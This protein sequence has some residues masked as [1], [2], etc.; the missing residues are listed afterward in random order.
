MRLIVLHLYNDTQLILDENLQ[1]IY[2]NGVL[3]RNLEL[4]PNVILMIDN[5]CTTIRLDQDNKLDILIPGNE[6][7]RA[8]FVLARHDE[9]QR[10]SF[11]RPMIQILLLQLA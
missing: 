1:E 3:M 11:R 2:K 10:Q 7:M 4:G 5:D 6:G 8:P 9:L